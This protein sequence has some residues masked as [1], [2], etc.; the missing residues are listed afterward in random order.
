MRLRAGLAK[1]LR[2]DDV[3]T[4][5]A[6]KGSE[7]ALLFLLGSLKEEKGDIV[8]ERRGKKK[9]S[10]WSFVTGGQCREFGAAFSSFS[11]GLAGAVGAPGS[12]KFSMTGAKALR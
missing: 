3:C 2:V 1:C 9:G 7:Q 12:R 6:E 11:P 10:V 8:S 5:R 4:H